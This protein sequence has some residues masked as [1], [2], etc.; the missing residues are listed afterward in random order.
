MKNIALIGP[1]YDCMEND[2]LV[3]SIQGTAEI[4]RAHV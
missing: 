1:I 4:G 2:D 3:A